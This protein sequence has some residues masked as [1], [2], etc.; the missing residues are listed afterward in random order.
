MKLFKVVEAHKLDNLVK[1][2]VAEEGGME[3]AKEFEVESVP[4]VVGFVGGKEVDRVVGNVETVV[5]E[6]LVKKTF[7]K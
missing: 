7:G 5:L 1:V 2:N 6:K 4:T 3:V